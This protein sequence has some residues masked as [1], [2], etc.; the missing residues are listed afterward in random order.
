MDYVLCSWFRFDVEVC[1][2]LNDAL[3]WWVSSCA[4]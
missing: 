2:V 4:E 3:L 1:F